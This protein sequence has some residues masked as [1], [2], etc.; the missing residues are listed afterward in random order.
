[1]RERPGNQA[2]S[3]EQLEGGQQRRPSRPPRRA[4]VY[5]GNRGDWGVSVWLSTREEEAESLARAIN[6]WLRQKEAM[7]LDEP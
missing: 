1:M 7:E 3:V 5:L 4:K 6:A 2:V